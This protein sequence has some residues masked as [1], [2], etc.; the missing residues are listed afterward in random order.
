MAFEAGSRKNLTDNRFCSPNLFVRSVVLSLVTR[1]FVHCR[2]IFARNSGNRLSFIRRAS[3]SAPHTLAAA[4]GA[5]VSAAIFTG[6]SGIDDSQTTSTR[7]A[8][9]RDLCRAAGK[10]PLSSLMKPPR[11]NPFVR[12][13]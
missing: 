12:A 11:L 5:Q 1:S 13:H 2:C 8:D 7:R 3:V 4:R 6:N 10:R 9:E